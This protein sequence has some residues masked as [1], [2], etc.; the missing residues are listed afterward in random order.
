VLCI[1]C[2]CVDTTDR[3]SSTNS[4]EK[5]EAAKRGNPARLFIKDNEMKMEKQDSFDRALFYDMP[6]MEQA[7]KCSDRH[8]RNLRTT[9]RIPQPVKLGGRV[10]WSKKV[11]EQW[12]DDGCPALAV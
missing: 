9:G 12:I 4:T 2:R 11:I 7:L 3:R 8:I 10:L 5:P 6:D 1:N